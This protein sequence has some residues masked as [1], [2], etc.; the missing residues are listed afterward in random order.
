MPRWKSRARPSSAMRASRFP[1]R[2]EEVTRAARRSWSG[3]GERG[4]KMSGRSARGEVMVWLRMTSRERR[5]VSTS[6]SSGIGGE[7]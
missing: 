4:E 5:T 3:E 1:V 7:G 6:G 2:T